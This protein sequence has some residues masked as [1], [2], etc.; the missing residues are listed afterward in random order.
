[1]LYPGERIDSIGFSDLKLIQKP[2]D[3][4]YG[5]DAVILA[6]FAAEKPANRIADLGTGTGIIPLI[7]SHKTQAE[8]IYGIEYQEES[9]QRAVRSAQLN[10]LSDRLHFVQAN[11]AEFDQFSQWADAVTSNPPYMAGKGGITNDNR[12]KTIARHETVGSLEDFIRCAFRILK[13]RGDF[14]MV[15]RPSRLVDIFYL[16]R[17]YHMEPKRMRLVAPG[18]GQAANIVLLHCVKNGGSE[19][20]LMPPLYVY[21]EQGIYSD[22]IQRIYERIT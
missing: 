13:D 21:K 4:C 7:L 18:E 6:D 16:C 10:G 8:S 3:F 14:Y 15:H 2:K 9:F 11:V 20:K 19:L 1:M 22:E 17:K 5:I 12:A